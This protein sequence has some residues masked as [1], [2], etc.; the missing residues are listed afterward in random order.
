MPS[1]SETESDAKQRDARDP[2]RRFR[3]E[4]N[5]PASHNGAPCTYLCGNSLGL[6]P[7]RSSRYVSE[8]LTKWAKVGV[9]GHFTGNR[10]WVTIDEKSC[11]LFVDVVGAANPDEI[12]VM[13]TLSTNIHLLMIAFY[14]P[15]PTRFKILIEGQAFCS[16][17]HIIRSQIALHGLDVEDALIEV[18]PRQGEHHVREED[19]YAIIEDQGE[20]IA[21]VFLGGVQYL[22]GQLFPMEE[23]T[24]RGHKAGC[25]VG[26]DLAH[27]AGNV[28]LH[29]HDWEV[30]FAAWCTYKY[31][32]SGPGSISGAF[33]HSRHDCRSLRKCAGWWGQDPQ[34]RFKMNH[35][36]ESYRGAKAFQLSNPAVLP[37]VCVQAS[38][39]LFKE[40][41]GMGA[42][43]K[44]SE[45][46]TGYLEKLLLE[47]QASAKAGWFEIMTPQ[48]KNKRGCQLSLFFPGG[49]D[50]PKKFLDHNGIIVDERRPSVIRVSPAPLYNSFHDVWIF[51][52]TLMECAIRAKL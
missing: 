19:I 16:D 2:L 37:V 47:V 45:A 26:F 7:K 13:N 49:V 12:V 22:T 3:Q 5:Y 36:H 9:E 27:A 28:P 1:L 18:E 29:L 11:E 44:K 23:L 20:S 34:T 32:N 48:D 33:V 46:L 35:E 24:R 25:L 30:D 4:F 43:R 38:L 52:N 31:L 51:A 39:E 50:E 21:L 14:R 17:H 40:A 42:L 8:E 10:P 6:L 15:T 41:G